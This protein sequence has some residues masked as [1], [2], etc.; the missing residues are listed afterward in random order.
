[1]GSPP[2]QEEGEGSPGA[3]VAGK[4]IA[5]RIVGFSTATTTMG[6]KAGVA[7]TSEAGETGVTGS[8]ISA[9]WFPVASDAAMARG[10]E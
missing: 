2:P 1:M 8:T 9:A 6:G 10:L 5:S 7:G 4:C 3:G